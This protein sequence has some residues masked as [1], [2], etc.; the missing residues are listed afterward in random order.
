[1]KNG[2]KTSPGHVLFRRLSPKIRFLAVYGTVI[3][4]HKLYKAAC[5]LGS[6]STMTWH[7]WN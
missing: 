1:M 6:A 3:P 4:V 5:V 2:Y 7:L